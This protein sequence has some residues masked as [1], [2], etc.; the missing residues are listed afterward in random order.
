M[1]V[2]EA[3][4]SCTYQDV[5]FQICDLN[6]AAL[7]EEEMLSAAWAYYFFSVQF[8]ENLELACDLYPEDVNLARL[9]KEE[10]ATSN[11]SPF[12]PVSAQ[13]EKMD[14]DEFMRRLLCLNPISDQA[15]STFTERGN[16]YLAH[17][18]GLDPVARA[19]SI[20][21]Y[22]NGGL[23]RVFTA[24]LQA[25]DFENP[26]LRAFRFFL[27]EHIRFDSDPEQGHGSLSR[28]LMPDESVFDFWSAFRQLF[29]EFTPR[30]LAASS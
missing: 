7:S 9:K 24:I 5:I 11:L 12:P 26:A 17:I 19:L 28:H 15:R 10:C 20:S 2:L 18:R 16:R 3:S 21:S 30:L 6:W 8:R 13:G 4:K 1:L 23:E 29:V 14:H 25:P 27:S 22:E